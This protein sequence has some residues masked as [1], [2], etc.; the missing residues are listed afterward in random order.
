M[1]EGG[2]GGAPLTSTAGVVPISKLARF[3]PSPTAG[4]AP[5]D[6]KLPLCTCHGCVPDKILRV[7]AA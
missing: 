4:A 6:E 3:A 7:K 2:F 1:V 5:P